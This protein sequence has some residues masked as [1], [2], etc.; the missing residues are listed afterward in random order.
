MLKQLLNLYKIPA[1]LAITLSIFI[2][3]FTVET[4]PLQI[5]LIVAGSIL[6][7][8]I[9]DLDY[10]LHAFFL[11]PDTD[12]SVSLRSYI[13]HKDFKSALSYLN[14]HKD[15]V[16]EKTLNSGLFQIMLI[17][18]LFLVI[19]STVNIFVKVFLLSLYANSIYKFVENY[20]L[21]RSFEDWFWFVRGT[22]KKEMVG[23]YIVLLLILFFYFMYY[24]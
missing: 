1:V 14:T 23:G 11:E 2:I 10:F 8:L 9:L 15:E 21:H 6:G 12:F 3:S 20:F 24:I 17:G 4:R 18:I 22:P 7:S 19:Y 13:R 5:G 16:K